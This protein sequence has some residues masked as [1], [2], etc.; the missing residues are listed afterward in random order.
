MSR[1][2]PKSP[3]SRPAG[4]RFGSLRL[5]L[6]LAAPSLAAIAWQALPPRFAAAYADLDAELPALTRWVFEHSWWPWLLPAAVL[7]LWLAAPPA[8]RDRW[9][10]RFGASA[11]MALIAV[12]VVALYL[13][14][15]GRAAAL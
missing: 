9:A 11:G 10:G 1:R 12:L 6:G 5:L 3:P 4:P 8:L 7:A 13:P 2:P 15:F 14:M